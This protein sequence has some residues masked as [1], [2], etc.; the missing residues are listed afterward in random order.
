[1]EKETDFENEYIS[2]IKKMKTME[3][4]KYETVDTERL[5]ELIEDLKAEKSDLEFER[6]YMRKRERARKRILRKT[7]DASKVPEIVEIKLKRPPKT[8]D[9]ALQ[10]L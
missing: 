5:K 9:E 6:K 3:K 1:M 4:E 7:K 2:L 10:T 8:F